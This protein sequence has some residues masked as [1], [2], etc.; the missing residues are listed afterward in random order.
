MSYELKRVP[1]NFSAPLNS[2]WEGYRSDNGY[3]KVVPCSSCQGTG[4]DNGLDC[5]DCGGQGFVF[6]NHYDPPTG[7]GY[8]VWETVSAGSPISPV[9]VTPDEVVGWLVAAGYTRAGSQ[10]FVEMGW[11]PSGIMVAGHGYVDAIN[12]MEYVN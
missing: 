5:E 11:S 2:I 1:L 9:F 10:K 8:Q 12:C 3:S 4:E 7:D 6:T